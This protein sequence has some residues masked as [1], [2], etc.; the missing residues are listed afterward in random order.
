MSE[1]GNIVDTEGLSPEEVERLRRVHELLLEAGPPPELPPELAHPPGARDAD[2][3]QFPLFP[4]RR[5]AAAFV[6]AAAVVAAVFGGGYLLGHSKAKPAT[7]AVRYA[8]TMR[9]AHGA[10][11][12]LQVGKKDSVGNYPMLVSV[13]GLPEQH[14]PGAYYELWL[15]KHGRPAV[16]CGSFRVHGHLTTVRLSVP[17]Q[18]KHYDGWIVTAHQPGR[19]EPG[20]AVLA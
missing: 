4:R 13:E 15:M 10:Q 19:P 8:V 6:A 16:P 12:V 5:H 11:A 7:L 18:L 3:I 2:V 9:G 14:A 20:P 17:Y 1:F